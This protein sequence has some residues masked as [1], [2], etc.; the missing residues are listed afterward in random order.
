[1][2]GR[3]SVIMN[4]Q[5][6]CRHAVR[7]LEFAHAIERVLESMRSLQ[8]CDELLPTQFKP[9]AP[10]PAG[11]QAGAVLPKGSSQT[12]SQL[13][14][15]QRRTRPA[16]LRQ[17]PDKIKAGQTAGSSVH[18]FILAQGSQTA[19]P[20]SECLLSQRAQAEPTQVLGPNYRKE[21]KPELATD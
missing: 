18:L 17:T 11:L 19:N 12:A 5:T 3:E 15:L 21:G 7:Q 14:A 9:L 10:R 13:Q 6:M 20:V 1:M 4:V 8:Q 16:S 2:C